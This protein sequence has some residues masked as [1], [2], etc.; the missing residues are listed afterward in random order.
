MSRKK[1]SETLLEKKGQELEENLA[2]WAKENSLLKHGEVLEF[3]LCIIKSRSVFSGEVDIFRSRTSTPPRL[4]GVDTRY[5]SKFEYVEPASLGK[6]QIRTLLGH[7]S[8]PTHEIF[9]KLLV[10]KRNSPTRSDELHGEME[11]GKFWKMIK[12]IEKV[13]SRETQKLK[14]VVRLESGV[15]RWLQLWVIN[16]KN[17][18]S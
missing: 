10:E 9:E 13:L 3:K 8:G 4:F 16:S 5:N 12:V 18:G 6:K 2:K 7:F 1:I 14:L 17:F 11:F 15:G